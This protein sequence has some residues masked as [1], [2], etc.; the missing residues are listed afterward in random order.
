MPA[1]WNNRSKRWVCVVHS[2]SECV[3]TFENKDWLDELADKDKITAEHP[4]EPSAKEIARR[5]KQL[6]GSIAYHTFTFWIQ[7]PLTLKQWVALDSRF[8]I[9]LKGIKSMGAGG[10]IPELKGSKKSSTR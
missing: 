1:Q 3:R 10:P 4:L 8:D 5:K 7:E 6:K 2:Q 9:A